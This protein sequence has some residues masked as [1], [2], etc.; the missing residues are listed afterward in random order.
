[1]RKLLLVLSL[2]AAA[3]IA[4]AP[5]QGSE[6]SRI[7]RFPVAGETWVNP[8]N[9]E[10][11]TLGGGV[12]QVVTHETTDASG[13]E[14]LIAEGNAKGVEGVGDAGNRYRATGGFWAE[15]NLNNGGDASQIFT[16]TEVLN[17]VSRGSDDNFTVE[18]VTHITVNS[19]GDVTS[20]FD[21]A[22]DGTCRG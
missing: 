12:F 6:P 19:N 11:V 17:L 8:C 7:E 16:I 21:L 14:H 4:A 5:A 22:A 2:L 18:T 10:T 9:G 3:V 20:D 1:M 15:F 13:G